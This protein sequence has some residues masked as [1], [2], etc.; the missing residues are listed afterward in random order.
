V[1]RIEPFPFETE[2]AKMELQGWVDLEGPLSLDFAMGVVREG[3][4]IEG[5]GA[6]ALDVLADDEGWVMIPLSVTG[7]KD[8]P[9]VRPDTRALLAQ[10]GQGMKRMATEKA[11]DA[12]KGLF[13]KKK[14]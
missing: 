2:Q 7:T 1:V 13:R 9:R 14:P 3:I 11:T 4:R 8:E 5:V 6:D 10:A 12:I